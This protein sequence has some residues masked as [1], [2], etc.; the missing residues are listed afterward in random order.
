MSEDDRGGGSAACQQQEL[1]LI[2]AIGGADWGVM[3]RR[4]A[5]PDG[6]TRSGGGVL[7]PLPMLRPSL[8]EDRRGQ[9]D[10]F[11]RLARALQDRSSRL[12]PRGSSSTAVCSWARTAS[13]TRR[14]ALITN[15]GASRWIM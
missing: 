3:P 10:G 15:S 9:R 7:A 13:T 8:Q 11:Q 12:S 6:G 1:T 2:T 5:V 14:I 4:A